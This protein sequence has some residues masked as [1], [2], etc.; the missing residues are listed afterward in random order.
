MGMIVG[1]CTLYYMV[2]P[3]LFKSVRF[4]RNASFKNNA[5]YHHNLYELKFRHST[6]KCHAC[7]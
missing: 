7:A 1:G 3:W 6:E 4:R 2:I 5:N